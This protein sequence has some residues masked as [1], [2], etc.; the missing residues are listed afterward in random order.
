MGLETGDTFLPRQHSNSGFLNFFVLMKI[1]ITSLVIGGGLA[2]LAT[3]GGIG[4]AITIGTILKKRKKGKTHNLR[5][6]KFVD[7]KDISFSKKKKEIGKKFKFSDEKF[8][9]DAGDAI[10]NYI[11]ELK[12]AY[13]NKE[14]LQKVLKV[15]EDENGYIVTHNNKTLMALKQANCYKRI[16]CQFESRNFLYKSNNNYSSDS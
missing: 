5:C 10:E 3:F 8:G 11:D 6:M 2:T 16:L 15:Y 7:L 4:G 13:K 14:K 1:L 9:P 12:I